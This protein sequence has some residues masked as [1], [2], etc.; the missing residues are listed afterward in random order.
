MLKREVDSGAIR[1][2]TLWCFNSIIEAAF[3]LVKQEQ[4]FVEDTAEELDHTV[5]AGLYGEQQEFRIRDSMKDIMKVK[6]QNILRALT[7]LGHARV[8]LVQSMPKA[9]DQVK[10]VAQDT[11]IWSK[12]ADLMNTILGQGGA[13][14]HY[15]YNSSI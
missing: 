7:Q 10:D 12:Y 5:P 4:L 13:I 14:K 8:L 9:G 11:P 15:G 6:K 2:T 1:E 3:L